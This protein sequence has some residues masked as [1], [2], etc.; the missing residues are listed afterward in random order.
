VNQADEAIV[1]RGEEFV[2]GG[3]DASPLQASRGIASRIFGAI[4][5]GAEPDATVR[6]RIL[7]VAVLLVLASVFFSPSSFYVRPGFGSEDSWRLTINRAI[8]EGWGFGDRIIWTYGPLGF[9]ETR[10]PYGISPLCFAALDLF[11]LLVFVWLAFDALKLKFNSALAWACVITLFTCKRLI[12]D[13]A[14]AALYCVII[15]LL[16]R[17]LAKPGA[18]ASVALVVASVLGL[19]VKVNFGLVSLFLCALIFLVKAIGREKSAMLWLI[20]LAAQIGGACALASYLNTNLIAYVKSALAIVR[21]YN[22]GMALGPW[23]EWAPPG[24]GI[25]HWMTFLFFWAFVIAAIVFFR[26]RGFSKESVLLMGLVGVATFVLYKTSVVRAI[27]TI[28]NVF[29]SASRLSCWP[30]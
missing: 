16:I 25:S 3:E 23:P 30:C 12:H 19:F 6:E 14:S 10:C 18:V 22:D 27:T 21:Q 17:N 29:C 26:R 2:R 24:F 8:T 4:R 28:T 5:R 1:E 13:Q 11:V 9:Y 15:Y 7:T 20:L